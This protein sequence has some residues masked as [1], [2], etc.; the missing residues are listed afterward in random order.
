MSQVSMAPSSEIVQP[1]V[2][3]IHCSGS[4]FSVGLPA[5]GSSSMSVTPSASPPPMFQTVIVN[6][7]S[8]PGI[9]SGSTA[10]FTILSSG[11]MSSFVIVQVLSSP[12][13]SSTVP[14]AAQSPPQ[15]PAS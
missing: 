6:A 9:V 5:G 13:A 14:S 15:V 12:I 8:K 4:R 10:D 1:G 7:M 2:V 11:G 3:V